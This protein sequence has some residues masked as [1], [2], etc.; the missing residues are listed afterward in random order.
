MRAWIY[1]QPGTHTF[2]LLLTTTKR[3]SFSDSIV[4]SR[5]W[6]DGFEWE[7]V[8]CGYVCD[9]VNLQIDQWIGFIESNINREDVFELQLLWGEG[10]HSGSLLKQ[11]VDCPYEL[12]VVLILLYLISSLLEDLN[13]HWLVAQANDQAEHWEWWEL[14]VAWLVVFYFD[15]NHIFVLFFG[16]EDVHCEGQVLVVLWSVGVPY[17]V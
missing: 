11:I 8:T 10:E 4:F 12:V 2:F 1:Y 15:C 13:V 5:E 9:L 3:W 16:I 6:V 14:Q 17:C 7:G